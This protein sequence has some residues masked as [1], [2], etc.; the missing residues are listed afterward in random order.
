MAF[1]WAIPAAIGAIGIGSSL[2]GKKKQV[3]DPL[4][5][6]R[7]QLLNLSG[8]VPGMV[9]R[10]KELTASNIAEARKE[11]TESIGEDVYASRGLGRTSIYDRLRTELIDKLAKT[12]AEAD[13]QAE[14]GGLSLQ[15]NLLNQAAG[16]NVPAEQPSMMSTLLGAGAEFAGQQ[17]GLNRLEDILKTGGGATSGDTTLDIPKNTFLEEFKKTPWQA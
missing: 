5:G 7:Q 1:E 17:F 9:A 4:A 11:G 10:Q 2:F 15:G 13:L 12:Q 16:V 8:Q 3:D 14:M 6:I